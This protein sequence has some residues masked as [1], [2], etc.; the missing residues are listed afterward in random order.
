MVNWFLTRRPRPLNGKRIVFST[1]GAGTTGYRHA[2]EGIWTPISHYIQK[3][4]Q[5]GYQ[6]NLKERAKTVKLLE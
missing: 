1:N 3:S 5:S 2:K 4:N 6:K